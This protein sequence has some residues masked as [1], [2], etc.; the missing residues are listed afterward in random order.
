MS[1]IKKIIGKIYRRTPVLK[2][3]PSYED[4]L[5]D[6]TPYG[7]E[8]KELVNIILEKTK[9]YQKK[10]A[11]STSVN[12]DFKTANLLL[13]LFYTYQSQTIHVLDFGGACGAHYFEVRKLLPAHFRLK[14]VVVETPTMVTLANSLANE[15]LSFEDDLD[16]AIGYLGSVDLLHTSGTLQYVNDQL[17]F[18]KRLIDV[19]A[20]YLLIN[21]MGFTLDNQP[22]I[23]IHQ[24][25]SNEH[26][27]G[28]L[29]YPTPSTIIKTPYTFMPKK[30]FDEIIAPKYEL[31]LEFADDSGIFP[32]NQNPMIGRGLFFR[33]NNNKDI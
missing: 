6:A 9:L 18:L 3:Y 20:N 21:R 8:D 4:A 30:D 32:V 7:Y 15:E 33:L 25:Y 29:S 26:G 27:V 31:L 28:Q 13:S 17:S 11:E 12:I 19:K 14:W 10:L 2:T 1:L 24:S 22:I 5:K 23:I 16:R